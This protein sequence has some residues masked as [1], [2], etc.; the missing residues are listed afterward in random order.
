MLVIECFYHKNNFRSLDFVS[1]QRVTSLSFLLLSQSCKFAEPCSLTL[2]N[3]QWLDSF[4]DKL[5]ASFGSQPDFAVLGDKIV[6][7]KEK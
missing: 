3:L 2:K 5:Q 7:R 1:Y 6:C 4:S